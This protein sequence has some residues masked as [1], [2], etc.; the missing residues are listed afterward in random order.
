M[1]KKRLLRD[2][3][4][5]ATLTQTQNKTRQNYYAQSLVILTNRYKVFTYPAAVIGDLHYI[6]ICERQIV[7]AKVLKKAKILQIAGF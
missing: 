2:S 3:H 6:N 5:R 7:F 4:Q 1:Y